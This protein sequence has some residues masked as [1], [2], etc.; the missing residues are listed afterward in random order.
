MAFLP[1]GHI[2]GIQKSGSMVVMDSASGAVMGRVQGLPKVVY[3][4]DAGLLDVVLDPT[5]ASNRTLYFTYVEPRFTPPASGNRP[6]F[7]DNGLAVAKAQLSAEEDRLEGLNV[8]LRVE[9]S[10]PMPAHYGSRLLFTRDGYLLVSVGERFFYPSRG[11]A[12]SL[13]AP[14][15][16]ILRITT[17]GAPA[18]GNPFDKDQLRTTRLRRSGLMGTAIRRDWRSIL[19]RVMFGRVNTVPRAATRST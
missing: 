6:A 8:I 13:F 10:F 2:L 19:Q 5:F 14:F 15:G 11:L 18:P 1:T 17:D 3:M 4:G 16:K 9:P 12:Q 7:G